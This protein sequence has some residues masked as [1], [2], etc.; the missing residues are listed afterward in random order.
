MSYI[1]SY[2]YISHE[3]CMYIYIYV[4]IELIYI[5]IQGTRSLGMTFGADA[6]SLFKKQKELMVNLL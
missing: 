3:I 1:I 6:E 5:Y 2:I 4:C